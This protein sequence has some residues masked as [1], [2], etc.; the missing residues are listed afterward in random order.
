MLKWLVAAFIVVPALE[1]WGL[2]EMGRLIGGWQTFG[3]LLL[4][5]FLGAYLAKREGRKVLRD[6]QQQI[7]FG[8]MP[9][10]SILDGICIFLGGILLMAPGFI[11]DIVGFLL[12]FPVTR[13]A[14]KA[15]ILLLIR[16]Q[17]AK[18]NRIMYFRR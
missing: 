13:P 18:G 9:A 6:A 11:S 12:V 8:Q 15:L 2:F 17:M 3:L 4:T 10:G 14:F 16:K 1:I 7:S 5:G